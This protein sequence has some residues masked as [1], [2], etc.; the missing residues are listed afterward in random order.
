MKTLVCKRCKQEEVEVPDNRASAICEFCVARESAQLK[1]TEI[2]EKRANLRR[3]M[4]NIKAKPAAAMRWA[5][6][7]S[8]RLLQYFDTLLLQASAHDLAVAERQLEK[9]QAKLR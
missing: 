8:Q 7:E 6:P 4:E 5:N 9:Y 2:E 3:M 1:V